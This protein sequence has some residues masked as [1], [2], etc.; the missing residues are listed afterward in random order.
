MRPFI[1][2]DTFPLV[3][4]AHV[5]LTCSESILDFLAGSLVHTAVL[6]S[7]SAQ[8]FNRAVLMYNYELNPALEQLSP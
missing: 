1:L 2:V 4:P 6:R 8:I 7:M 3:S 5:P